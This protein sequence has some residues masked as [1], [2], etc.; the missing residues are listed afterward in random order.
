VPLGAPALGRTTG[1]AISRLSFACDWVEEGSRLGE[2]AASIEG[3]NR[4]KTAANLPAL[5]VNFRFFAQ[6][7]GDNRQVPEHPQAPPIFL[8]DGP[9]EVNPVHEEGADGDL[10][11]LEGHCQKGLAAAYLPKFLFHQGAIPGPLLG[12][13]QIFLARPHGQGKGIAIGFKG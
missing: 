2:E 7:E 13:Y 10:I 3:G 6:A 12:I 9:V 5:L 11:H 8:T 4:K 1:S